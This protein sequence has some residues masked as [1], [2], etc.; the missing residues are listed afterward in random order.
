MTGRLRGKSAVVT[1]AAQ[2]IGRA[3]ALAFAAEGAAVLATDIN[4]EKLGELGKAGEGRIATRRLDVTK[5]DEIA[6]LA[7]AQGAVDILL[8]CAG[9][10]HHGTILDCAEADW[11]FS[12][13]L[14]LR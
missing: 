4:E 14:N 7:A 2:G 5:A 10:V 12:M 9:F 11:N 6:A 3:A 8:N 13:N 1:A